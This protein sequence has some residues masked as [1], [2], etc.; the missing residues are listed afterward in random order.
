M[1]NPKRKKL[2]KPPSWLPCPG[3]DAEEGLCGL[4]KK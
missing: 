2:L 4:Q 3:V 1:T